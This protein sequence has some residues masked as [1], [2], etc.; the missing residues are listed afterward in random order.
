[1]RKHL[2][3]PVGTESMAI[4]SYD[5]LEGVQHSPITAYNVPAGK[6]ALGG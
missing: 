2:N 1:M 5:L 4:E 6:R 3:Y